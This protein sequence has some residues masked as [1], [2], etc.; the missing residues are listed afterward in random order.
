[1]EKEK[2]TIP[3]KPMDKFTMW[4][5][6]QQIMHKLHHMGMLEKKEEKNGDQYGKNSDTESHEG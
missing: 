5:L 3:V 2:N 6:L 1:M 4:V